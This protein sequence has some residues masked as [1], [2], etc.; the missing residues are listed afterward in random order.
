MLNTV[1][2]DNQDYIEVMGYI[3]VNNEWILWVR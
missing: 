3:F 1:T 2:I